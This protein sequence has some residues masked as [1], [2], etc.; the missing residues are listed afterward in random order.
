MSKVTIF[1]PSHKFESGISHYTSR[2]GRALSKDHTV[3]YCLFRDLL[4]RFLFPGKKRVSLFSDYFSPQPYTPIDWWN[5]VSYIASILKANRSDSIIFEW[6]TGAVGLQYIIAALLLRRKTTILEYHECIDTSEDR[7]LFSGMYSRCCLKV[8]SRL[9]SAG[10]FHSD[11]ELDSTERCYRPRVSFVIPHGVYDGHGGVTEHPKIPTYA[12]FNVLFFG[13]VR[14]YK[15]VGNLIEAFR[16]VAQPHWRLWIVGEEWDTIDIPDD[17]R[18]RRI[19]GYVDETALQSHFDR[20]HVVVLPYT[21]ASQS[22]VSFIAMGKGLPI[23]ASDV[24]G[25]GESLQEYDGAWLVQPGNVEEIME[26]L[27]TVEESFNEVYP[28]DVPD[29][30]K[31]GNIAKK[32]RE[33][34]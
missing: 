18:I 5:I 33:I 26:S 32:W 24:G 23:I 28:A 3:H 19:H 34:L 1:G 31:W 12:R 30:F 29:K 27:C 22:G 15:G 11:W 2:L 21:R 20:A 10:V 16:R 6:W 4:P 8:L 13:L 25:L 14:E 9:V 7:L 17:D